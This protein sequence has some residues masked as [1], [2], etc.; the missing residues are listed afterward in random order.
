MKKEPKR[1]SKPTPPSETLPPEHISEEIYYGCSAFSYPEMFDKIEKFATKNG[2]EV[3]QISIEL[4]GS[5]G[6]YGDDSYDP[7]LR[8]SGYRPASPDPAYASKK[9]AY[10]VK[11]SLYEEKMKTYKRELKEY[12]DW[13]VQDDIRE[14]ELLKEKT[15]AR[16]AKLKSV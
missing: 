11:V 13:K 4:S 8:I 6:D 2:I 14:L 5:G 12:K 9:A 10:D 15:E 3:D 1:P 7:S 16:L